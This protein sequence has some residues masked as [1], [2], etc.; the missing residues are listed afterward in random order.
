MY[1][2]NTENNPDFDP[3]T[4]GQDMEMFANNIEKMSTLTQKID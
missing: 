4:I 2:F 3:A 1:E